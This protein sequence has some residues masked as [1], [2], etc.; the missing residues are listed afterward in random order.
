MVLVA[1]QSPMENGSGEVFLDFE[2]IDCCYCKH[3]MENLCLNTPGEGL[4]SGRSGC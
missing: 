4:G 3:E 2:P 1:W